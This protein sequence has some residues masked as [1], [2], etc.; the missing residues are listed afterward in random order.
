MPSR[1]L[2][3]QDMA[4]R[5]SGL[6]PAIA[7]YLTE[8]AS[9]CLARHHASPVEFDISDSVEVMIAIAHWVA[10]DRRTINAHANEIDATE[11]G[12]CA[13]VLAAVELTHEFVAVRRAET[14]TGADYYIAPIGEDPDD[15]EGCYRLE[16]S[17]VDRGNRNSE[18]SRLREKIQQTKSGSCNLP[19]FAGVVG[20]NERLILLSLVND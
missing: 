3:I 12:A 11:I 2:P 8:A 1:I 5:H 18:K 17:G 15:L 16:V 20:F 9:V 14:Q 19:A 10:P 6:T 4:E 13:C 7:G